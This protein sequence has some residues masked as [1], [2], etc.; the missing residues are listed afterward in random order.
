M[1]QIFFL[2]C[3]FTNIYTI[4]AQDY[5]SEWK[6]FT[7][8]G[9]LYSIASEEN[10]QNLSETRFVDNLLNSVRTNI[11]KQVEIRIND[12]AQLNKT[13]I[14]GTSSVSYNAMTTFSTDVNIKL[15][16]T[17]HYYNTIN[18]KG[19]AIAYIEKQTAREYYEKELLT[20]L[21]KA[22]NTISE[23]ENLIKQGFKI[24]AKN[25]LEQNLHIFQT[26]DEPFFWLNIFEMPK[27][28][29][30]EWQNKLLIREQKSKSL[31]TEL[32]H[33]TAIFLSCS[34]KLNGSN[35]TKLANE[36]KAELAKR[37]C[38]LTNN[39]TDADFVIHINCNNR[40]GNNPIVG[41]VRTFFSYIDASLTITKT[42]T[43]QCI[44]EDEISVKGGHTLGYAEAARAAYKKVKNELSPILIEN[45]QQ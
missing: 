27:T 11:A 24:K 32:Q 38:N 12:Y 3:F 43:S 39:P 16:N 10:E 25:L 37:N 44:Y 34:A 7:S 30:S 41:G 13:A 42:A 6:K 9:Y 21:L 40:N 1:K 22:D 28:E 2:L 35:Y 19:Y 31:I 18:K 33:G 14:N 4:V 23:A 36:L 20:I 17:L 26:A 5:P 8:I 29:Y 45:I 15:L